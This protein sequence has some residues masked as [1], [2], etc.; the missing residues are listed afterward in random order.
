VLDFHPLNQKFT[1]INAALKGI[2]NI[3]LF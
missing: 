3:A 2:T 1:D